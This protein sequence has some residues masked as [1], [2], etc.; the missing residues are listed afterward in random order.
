MQLL[1]FLKAGLTLAIFT[2]GGLQY[3]PAQAALLVSDFYTN[4][5]LEYNEKTGDFIRVF[6]SGSELSNPTGLLFTPNGNL[7]VS[8]A[9]TGT[10]ESGLGKVLEYNGKTG[11]L[12]KAFTSN[13]ELK[14]P[15]GLLF[16]PNN[17]LLVADFGSGTVLEYDGTTGAFKRTFSTLGNTPDG[18]LKRPV[19]LRYGLNGNLL[20][21]IWTDGSVLEFDGQTGDFVRTFVSP[22]SGGLNV[23]ENLR[24]SP[25][26]NLLVSSLGR[27]TLTERESLS[28][29]IEYNGQTGEFIRTL[30]P[31]NTGGLKNPTGMY[32]T[33]NGTLLVATFNPGSILEYNVDTGELI[34]TLVPN[35]SGGLTN[36]TEIVLSPT[37][38][39]ES[40]AVLGTLILGAL[41]V[42][43]IGTNVKNKQVFH[44]NLLETDLY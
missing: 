18:E 33:P 9:G 28:S 26:G 19:S 1:T 31:D 32:L 34:R 41:G 40:S 5:V 22:G 29:V 37:S 20:V 35:G 14:T 2:I 44:K 27:S 43:R 24:F 6:A 17:D 11:E 39:P 13:G 4:K 36:P 7:L 42:I 8:S 25:K 16:A 23:A 15:T 30:I 12:V 10:L 3:L 21:S 38:V